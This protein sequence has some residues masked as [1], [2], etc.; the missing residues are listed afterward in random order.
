MYRLVEQK[1]DLWISSLNRSRMS[2]LADRKIPELAYFPVHRVGIQH[3]HIGARS[4]PGAGVV[5]AF[6][7]VN[8]GSGIMEGVVGMDDFSCHVEDVEPDLRRDTKGEVDL[9]LFDKGIGI[10]AVNFD[11]GTQ[12]QRGLC[13]ADGRA[14]RKGRRNGRRQVGGVGQR[15]RGRGRHR[16][17]PGKAG[18]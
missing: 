14:D 10:E 9:Q 11:Q 15:G 13:R 18:A 5:E 7:D 3:Q 17:S 1:Q 8:V 4:D 12:G 2:A 6:P 16:G